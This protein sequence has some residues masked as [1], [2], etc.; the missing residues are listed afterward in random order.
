MLRVKRKMSSIVVL[1]S[2]TWRSCSS[3]ITAVLS[4]LLATA[5]GGG[6]REEAAS[7]RVVVAAST[8]FGGVTK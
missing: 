5:A 1:S 8:R 7:E 6:G 3:A 4:G 2:W